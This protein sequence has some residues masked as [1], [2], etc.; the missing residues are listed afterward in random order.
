M[1][2]E[3]KTQHCICCGLTFSILHGGLLNDGATANRV[4]SNASQIEVLVF[5]WKV[6]ISFSR[7]KFW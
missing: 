4:L 7:E 6:V 5:I 3:Q 1:E 2:R